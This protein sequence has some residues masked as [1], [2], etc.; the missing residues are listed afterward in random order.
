MSTAYAAEK[1]GNAVAALAVGTGTIQER[2]LSAFKSMGAISSDH[3][4]G[5]DLEEWE[6]IFQRA[7]AVE[8]PNGAYEATLLHLTVDDA[9]RLAQDIVNLDAML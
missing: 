4:T 3:F 2:L 8:G 6:S 5:T 7:I 1:L 9:V